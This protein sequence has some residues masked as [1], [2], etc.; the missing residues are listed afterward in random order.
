MSPSCVGS[1]KPTLARSSPLF[2]NKQDCFYSKRV[3]VSPNLCLPPQNVLRSTESTVLAWRVVPS[4]LVP[5]R[6]LPLH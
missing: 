5:A 1:W 3:K 2:L 6:R 4:Y